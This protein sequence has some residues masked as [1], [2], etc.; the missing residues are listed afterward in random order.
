MSLIPWSRKTALAARF[1][2]FPD[3]G[4]M[5][6]SMLAGL[7]GLS[8]NGDSAWLPAIDVKDDN[9]YVTVTAELPGVRRDDVKIDV[10][11]NRLTLRGEKKEEKSEKQDGWWHREATYGN[12]LRQITLPGEVDIDHAEA[13]MTDGVLKIRLPKLVATGAKQI[14]VG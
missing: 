2:N 5:L 3:V 13:K 8:T 14:K 7:P 6:E 4:D 11:G 1:P 9:K 10:T 12:F